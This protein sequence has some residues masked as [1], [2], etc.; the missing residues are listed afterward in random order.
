MGQ[1]LQRAANA[2]RR[3]RSDSP[4]PA[5]GQRWADCDPRSP[6]HEL[7]IAF[8]SSGDTHARCAVYQGGVA[9]GRFVT[10]ACARLVPGS[11]GYRYVGEGA[12]VQAADAPEK[13]QG[14]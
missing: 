7:V 1:G 3:T 5:A 14:R 8:L 9:T 12:P 2:A 4:A 6:G 10:V 11:R 13:E